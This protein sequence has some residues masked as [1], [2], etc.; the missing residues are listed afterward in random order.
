M[1]LKTIFSRRPNPRPIES[2]V[3]SSNTVVCK[4]WEPI[5]DTE[6]DRQNIGKFI[7]LSFSPKTFLKNFPQ[8]EKGDQIEVQKW[9]KMLIQIQ[10][11]LKSWKRSLQKFDAIKEDLKIQKS[12]LW[13]SFA[14][15]RD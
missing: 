2:P 5:A 15:K 9:L 3:K 8:I 10:M 12:I 4:V 6:T 13:K 1:F 7:V 14:K 11:T